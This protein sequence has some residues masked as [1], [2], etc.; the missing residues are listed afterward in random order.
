VADVDGRKSDSSPG[1]NTAVTVPEDRGYHCVDT[2]PPEI[3]TGPI[4]TPSPLNSTAPT[5]EGVTVAVSVT[6]SPKIAEGGSMV[7]VVDVA[8]G[9]GRGRGGRVVV[10]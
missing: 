7:S 9:S 6:A 3:R 5:A 2:V 1:M 4:L 8:V 10:G